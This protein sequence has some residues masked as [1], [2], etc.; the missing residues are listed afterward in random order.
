[1]AEIEINLKEKEKREREREKLCFGLIVFNKLLTRHKK[2][3]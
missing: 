1:M 2:M 3:S